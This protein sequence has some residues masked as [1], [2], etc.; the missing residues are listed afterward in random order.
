MNRQSKT[1]AMLIVLCL[2]SLSAQAG[3]IEQSEGTAMRSLEFY[4]LAGQTFT[5]EDSLLDTIEFGLQCNTINAPASSLTV[6]LYEWDGDSG[7]MGSLLTSAVNT[8]ELPAFRGGNI[9]VAFDFSGVSMEIDREYAAV[10]IDPAD[11]L[12]GYGIAWDSTTDRYEGGSALFR[13]GADENGYDTKFRVTSHVPVPA[14][15]WMLGSGL[16]GL[17]A[18]RRRK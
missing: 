4:Q 15:I 2:C 6:E 8:T 14:A 16:L 5:A 13:G 10:I 12:W 9:W 1:I 11:D 18:T 3:I 17:V 7:S